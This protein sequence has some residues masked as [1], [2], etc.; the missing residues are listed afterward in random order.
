MNKPCS[1]LIMTVAI[2][3]ATSPSHAA[4]LV[5]HYEFEDPTNL[6][7]DSSGLNNHAEVSD[8]EQVEGQFG[9]GGFFDESIPSSFV[10]SDGLSGFSGKPGVTLAAW[11]KLDEAATGFDGIISQDAGACCDNRILL[12]NGDHKP[13]INLSEHQDIHVTDSDPVEFGVWTHVA[14]VGMDVDG[15]AEAFV[16]VNGVKVEGGPYL[17]PEL[18]DGSE[19]NTYL[20][21][22]EAGTAH[23]LTGALDDVRIYEGALTDEEVLALLDPPRDGPPLIAH[24]PLDSDGNSA[25]GAFVASTVTD[26]EFG[27]A[28][29]NPNTGTRRYLQ[30]QFQCDPARLQ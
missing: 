15:E 16:Y 27:E 24:F 18:D 1:L 8:V 13:F 26:V 19:W 6:G 29:A 23:L 5:A 30:W 7:L 12:H 11:V 21:A 3:M 9:Q 25:D 4:E 28:G 20:G 2:L 14:M 10:K 22:G 17:F